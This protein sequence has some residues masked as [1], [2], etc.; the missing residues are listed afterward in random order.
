MAETFA[1]P[2]R[3]RLM[4]LL[5]KNNKRTEDYPDADLQLGT[6]I[7]STSTVRNTRL[8]VTRLVN[9]EP[10]ETKTIFYDRLNIAT[11]MQNI[12]PDLELGD[13]PTTVQELIDLILEDYGILL[14]EDEIETTLEISE[15][16]ELTLTIAAGSL[17]WIGSVTLT[18][19]VF[20]DI[21]LT[22]SGSFFMLDGG[23][24]LAN[25]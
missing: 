3:T 6:P 24:Y 9:N 25:N 22:D 10:T 23:G 16:N 1:L 13:T 21:M 18:V 14:E 19:P 8:G 11:K 5:K 4:T 2:A 20:Q 12:N 15:D 7:V 17:G